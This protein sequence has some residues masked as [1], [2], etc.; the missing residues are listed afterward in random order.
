[1]A[2]ASAGLAIA[3]KKVNAN[4][5]QNASGIDDCVPVADTTN[6]VAVDFTA[7]YRAKLQPRSR[8]RRGRGL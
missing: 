2:G 8:L 6:K 5:C 4:G 7:A 3:T 1:M